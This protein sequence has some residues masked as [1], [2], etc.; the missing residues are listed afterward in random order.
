M[1]F[2]SSLKA[3]LYN[4]IDRCHNCSL[5]GLWGTYLYEGNDDTLYACEQHKDSPYDCWGE[6]RG[7]MKAHAQEL[8]D[9]A[10]KRLHDYI[11]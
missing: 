6:S 1:I 5:V 9:R 4:E 7:D 11:Y 10:Y 8:A 2:S 3:C